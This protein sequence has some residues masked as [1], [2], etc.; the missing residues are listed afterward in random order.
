MRKRVVD[1]EAIATSSKLRRLPEHVRIHYPYMLTVALANGVFECD[2]EVV[3][4]KRYAIFMPSVT[5]ATVREMLLAFE[6]ADLLRT[7]RG[8]DGRLWR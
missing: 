1:G 2:A 7:W 4:A 3:W 6:N 8:K 5:S